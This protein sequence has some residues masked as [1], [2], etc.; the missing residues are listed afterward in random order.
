MKITE[1]NTVSSSTSIN[2][3]SVIITNNTF[4]IY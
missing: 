4:T 2:N 3:N 1:M